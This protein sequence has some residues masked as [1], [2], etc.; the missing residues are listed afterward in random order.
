M[1]TPATAATA[2]IRSALGQRYAPTVRA[3]AAHEAV[4]P[5][6]KPQPARKPQTGPS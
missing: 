6:T 2:T 3:M 1:V 4:L 5:T